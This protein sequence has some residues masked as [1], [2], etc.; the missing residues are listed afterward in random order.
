[1]YLL[2]TYVF[3]DRNLTMQSTPK[4]RCFL[5]PY[6]TQPV[7]NKFVRRNIFV[8]QLYQGPRKIAK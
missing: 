8:I 4:P 3:K 7:D 1:M 2:A 5:V 6:C